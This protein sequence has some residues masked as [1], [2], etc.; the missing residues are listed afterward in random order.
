MTT[1]VRSNQ[2]NSIPVGAFVVGDPY[3]AYY[4][5]LTGT[6]PTT[7]MITVAAD[8]HALR[9]IM[10]VINNRIEVESILDGGSQIVAMSQEV[11]HALGIAY[12]PEITL[13]MQSANGSTDRTL[14]LARNVPF[15]LGG[16]MIYL[17]VHILLK[18]AYDVLLGRPFDV[19]CQSVIR[20]FANEEQDITIVEPNSGEK[21]VIPTVPR[22]SHPFQKSAKPV[23]VNRAN[24]PDVKAE[25]DFH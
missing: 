16:L 8:S 24:V 13:I 9:S 1:E 12:N 21:T 22:G 5:G 15:N 11:C 25:V 7:E 17:Q 20:N 2:G 4:K 19:F 23:T 18:P 3:E 10:A 6:E 14:G